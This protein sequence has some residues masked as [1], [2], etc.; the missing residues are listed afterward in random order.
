MSLFR[1]S[2]Y[3]AIA[4]LALAGSRFALAAIVARRISAIEFGT[5]VYAQWLVDIAFLVCSLGATGAV[6]R[7]VAQYR[8]DPERLKEFLRHWPAWSGVLPLVAGC[9]VLIGAWLS[10]MKVDFPLAAALIVWAIMSAAWLLQTAALTGLQRFDLIL[11]ANLL[12][13]AIM[14]LG[15]WL[16]PAGSNM[17]VDLFWVMAA[18]AGAGALIG[19]S[20][21]FGSRSLRHSP[22]SRFEELDWTSI[23][24]Y[25]LNMWLIS[26]LWSL[27]WSRG[28]LPVVKYFLGEAGVA[29][30]S[31]V[32]TLF[33][34]AIQGV[35]LGLSAVAP[36]LTSLWG[37]GRRE[38]ALLLAQKIMNIQLLICGAAAI[39]LIYFGP[40][41]LSLVFG[42]IYRDQAPSLAVI[43]V[44]LISMVVANQNHILQIETNGVF[45]RNSSLVGVVLLFFCS[46]GLIYLFDVPGAAYSR[47]LVMISL[48]AISIYFFAKQWGLKY[49][50]FGNYV[51]VGFVLGGSVL[52]VSTGPEVDLLARQLYCLASL[53]VLLL[54]VKDFGGGSL[55]IALLK[56][57]W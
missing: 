22:S 57:R 43:S 42:G 7:Y 44:G 25:A 16:V 3:A 13:G 56:R 24:R 21:T 50:A 26:L 23:R 41:L 48:S 30:Y 38:E 18:A 5:F 40:E 46:S 52:V 29:R 20:Q 36:Q 47:A 49:I 8:D 31:A 14:L 28:E 55:A 51:F 10:G 39:I 19:V 15:A 35:M 27:L 4:A 12:A 54:G 2:S 45:T 6:S 33:S 53:T 11:A 1:Q 9:M 17:L 32:Q 37:A 34:G